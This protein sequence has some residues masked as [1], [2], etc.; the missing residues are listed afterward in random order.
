[1]KRI[2]PLLA[3]TLFGHLYS[4]DSWVSVAPSVPYTPVADFGVSWAGE[5][6]IRPVGD[7]TSLCVNKGKQ[8][9]ISSVYYNVGVQYWPVKDSGFELKHG[10]WHNVD[11]AGKL[12]RYNRFGVYLG[13][14]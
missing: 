3:V 13:I 6:K 2:L 5:H 8:R 11:R 7:I 12:E 1:M 14:R 4:K 10:S 9:G